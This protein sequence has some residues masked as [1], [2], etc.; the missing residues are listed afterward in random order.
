[1]QAAYVVSS[2]G[3]KGMHGLNVGRL[4]RSNKQREHA[5]NKEHTP[6]SWEM[7]RRRV[8]LICWM[9]DLRFLLYDLFLL[10]IHNLVLD[11]FIAQTPVK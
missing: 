1:M 4:R 9:L 8:Q 5:P 11:L 2:Q 3:A 10:F 6:S 7:A